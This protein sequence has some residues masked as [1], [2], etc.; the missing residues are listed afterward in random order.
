MHEKRGVLSGV[1]PVVTITSIILAVAFVL[2]CAV[3]A[4]RALGY[5]EEVSSTLLF[6]AKW[7]YIGSVSA[8]VL[9]LLYLMIS[10]YG[11]I[12]LG[13]DDEKPEFSFA[14]WIAMLFSGGMGIGLIFWSV[15]EPIWHYAS[16]PFTPPMSDASASMAMQL[17]FF[18]WGLHPWSVFIIVALALSY[19]SYRKNLPL[20]LRSILY[21]WIGDRI[22]GPIGHTIDI[23]TVV[24]TAFGISQTL[25]MGVLQ[26][27]TG[28]GEV[29]GGHLG[30]GGMLAI[31]VA[32]GAVAVLS[33]LSGVG[34]GFKRLAEMNMLLSLLLVVAL[35]CLG[36]TRYI[37]N[38]LLETTGNYVQHIVGMS[39]WSDAE[40]DSGWQNTWTAYYWPW[41]MTWAPFVGMF[42]ARISRGRTVRELIGGALIV[43]TLICFIWIAV[44]G[45][46]A[47]KVEQQAQQT[48]QQSVAAGVQSSAEPFTGG[49][50]LQATRQDTTQAV[51]ALFD[52]LHYPAM[53]TLL[54]VMIC[55]LLA[56]HFVI[57]ADSGTLVI[58]ILSA[59]GSCDP[60]RHIRV[61]WGVGVTAIA[62]VLLYAGGFK[63]MQ[64]ASI[65]AGFPVSLFI[66]V[67][68]ATLFQSIRREPLAWAMLP[69]HLHPAPEKLDGTAAGGEG[70]SV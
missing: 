7:F 41:W 50:V 19:F 10:R 37:L 24:V 68:A 35:L 69:V 45:G 9:F 38:T 22:Y 42:I 3:A 13:R 54:S 66:A 29:F 52:Q 8:V 5:F 64:A 65:I 17:T 40:K 58:S 60:P 62:A 39:L 28:I 49:P 70:K 43:P 59:D 47:L 1:N 34:K 57:T 33:V 15:A 18:H 12:R 36:P 51:F 55:V 53:G 67:M 16:N 44:F 20:T 21:P 14:A 6:G 11:H 32:L 48:H 23:L 27:N 26:I 4:D 25:G 46:T 56:M 63:V 31:V 61:L 2:F 30:Y